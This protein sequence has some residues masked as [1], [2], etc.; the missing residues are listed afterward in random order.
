MI[1]PLVWNVHFFLPVLGS[2]AMKHAVF[3]A[4]VDRVFRDRRGAF[5][6]RGEGVGIG[7]VDGAVR[8][9]F[10]AGLQVQ[11]E[12]VPVDG[13]DVNPA[14]LDR[15]GAGNAVGHFHLPEDF[16]FVRQ[17]GP[18]DAGELEVVAEG[19]PILRGRFLRPEGTAEISNALQQSTTTARPK[20]LGGTP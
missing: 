18:G 1:S 8:P 10:F 9:D 4:D 13:A 15:G 20:R 17:A 16:E 7:I 2:M 3:V 5:E 14:A 19:G 6:S 12:E 11:A